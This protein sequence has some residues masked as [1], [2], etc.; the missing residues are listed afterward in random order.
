MRVI[1]TYAVKGMQLLTLDGNRPWV[2][3][4][5]VLINGVEHKFKYTYNE[6][7]ILIDAPPEASFLGAEVE[8]PETV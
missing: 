8:F 2:D 5:K 7:T 3:E 1:D 4:Q 6:R